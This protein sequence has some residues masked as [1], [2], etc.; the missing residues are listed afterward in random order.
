MLSGIYQNS[1][2][3]EI[4]GPY[5]DSRSL[6]NS[7]PAKERGPDDSRRRVELLPARGELGRYRQVHHLA[8][9]GP[10]YRNGE[11]RHGQRP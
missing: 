11:S 1:E 8:G 6:K 5:S 9:F 3:K 7:L 4:A 2:D 10:A